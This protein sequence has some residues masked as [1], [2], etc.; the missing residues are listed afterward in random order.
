MR[1][2]R[3][4]AGIVMDALKQAG[5]QLVKE[6]RIADEILETISQPLI[7]EEELRQRYND[8]Y[9]RVVNEVLDRDG[10]V[11]RKFDAHFKKF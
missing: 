11:L 1:E 3:E 10:D 2:N 4:K 8:A 7:P 6:G 5:F 9:R